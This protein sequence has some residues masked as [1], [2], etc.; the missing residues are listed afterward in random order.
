MARQPDPLFLG[1]TR[2]A[3]VAGVSYSYFAFNIVVCTVYFV[4]TS[5][6]KVVLI[7]ALIHGFGYTITKKEPLA[8]ELLLAKLGKCPSIKNKSF[9]KGFNSYNKF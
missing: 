9:Y 2:P 4:I 6:F 8:V 3:L 5:D 1:L 7:A